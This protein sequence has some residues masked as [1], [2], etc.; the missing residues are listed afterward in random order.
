MY[1]ITEGDDFIIM[2]RD[3]ERPFKFMHYS[4]GK[5]ITGDIEDTAEIIRVFS[6]EQINE[7]SRMIEKE[8][9]CASS[10]QGR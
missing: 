3:E 6:F 8:L 9:A 4:E 10:V 1:L 7:L 2:C 5:V